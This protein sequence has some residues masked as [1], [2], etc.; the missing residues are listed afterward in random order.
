[1]T[2]RSFTVEMPDD[3]V[4][5][6]VLDYCRVSIEVDTDNGT[7]TVYVYDIDGMQVGSL[8]DLPTPRE[9]IE[10]A[11]EE[12]ADDDYTDDDGDGWTEADSQ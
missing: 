12:D 1:M 7:T 5:V 9:E 2:T 8:T 11:T 4:D 6:D 3:L 10:D